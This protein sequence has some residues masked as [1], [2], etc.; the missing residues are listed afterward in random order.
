MCPPI[1][2]PSDVASVY[3]PPKPVVVTPAPSPVP[4]ADP[5]APT[6]ALPLTPRP[7][8]SQPLNR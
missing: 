2:R 4:A 5:L 7:E 8:P 1:I 6:P 3:Q